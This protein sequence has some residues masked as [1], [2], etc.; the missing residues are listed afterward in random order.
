M[1]WSSFEDFLKYLAA[2]RQPTTIPKATEAG[3][4]IRKARPLVP[5]WGRDGT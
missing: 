1:N 5:K 3:V 4:R 2:S